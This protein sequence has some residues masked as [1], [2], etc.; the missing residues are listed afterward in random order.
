LRGLQLDDLGLATLYFFIS[1][2][3]FHFPPF[4]LD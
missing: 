2:S 1:P 4:E 3:S